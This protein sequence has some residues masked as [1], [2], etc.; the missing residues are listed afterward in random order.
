M[1]GTPVNPPQWGTPLG[2]AN[3][4]RMDAF[5]LL[6]GQVG[7]DPDGKGRHRI[8]A[9]GFVAQFQKALENVVEVVKAAG[10]APEDVLELT[11]YVTSMPEYRA[12]RRD[13][14]PAWK[15]VMGSHYPAMTLVA[16]SELFEEDA[17]VEIRGVAAV[18]GPRGKGR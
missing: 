11:I 13:L 1:V 10:G 4:M 15:R 5:L 14:G 18:G 16:V 6:A 2:Y 7:G 3:A 17:V 8:V 9:G 12:A